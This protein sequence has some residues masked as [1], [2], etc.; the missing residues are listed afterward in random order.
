MEQGVCWPSWQRRSGPT[1]QG[2]AQ[3]LQPYHHSFPELQSP[4]SAI[5]LPDNRHATSQVSPGHVHIPA[6]TAESVCLWL[7]LALLASSLLAGNRMVLAC[8]GV[9]ASS[10]LVS[11]V[12]SE[13]AIARLPACLPVLWKCGKTDGQAFDKVILTSSLRRGVVS[14]A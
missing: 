8:K 10:H 2:T 9:T 14:P 12:R 6:V 3:S 11:L 1:G 5:L 13:R 7:T 4:K